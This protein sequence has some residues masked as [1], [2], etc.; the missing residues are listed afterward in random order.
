MS[1]EP[2]KTGDVS[3]TKTKTL[4]YAD[5]GWGKTKQASYY[6]AAFGPGFVL[7]GE[8]GL[9]TL[10]K[11]QIDYLPFLR[12]D[13]DSQGDGAA[14]RALAKQMVTSEFKAMGYKWI[15]V[16][17]LTE[18]ADLCYK[19]F[20]DKGYKNGWDLYNDYGTALLGAMKWFRDL[21]YHVIVTSLVKEDRDDNGAPQYW[22]MMKGNMAQRQITGIFD[23]VLGGIVRTQYAESDERRVKPIVDRFM[24]TARVGGWTGKVRTPYPERVKPV[25]RADAGIPFLLRKLLMTE[26]NWK[27]YL[28]AEKAA[29][30]RLADTA[31]LEGERVAQP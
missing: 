15:M 30:E 24:V 18:L 29:E 11:D 5:A 12:W 9:I 31:N 27:T 1:F 7:S 26:T 23:N 20:Q 19:H 16:D 14:F 10:A 22:P 13:E 21:P 28:A 3:A 8:S 17:S 6:K 4:V 25:E 2:L